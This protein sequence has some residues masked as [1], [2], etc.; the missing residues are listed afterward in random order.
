ME[1]F[2][3]R[4]D[5]N[6]IKDFI[7]PTDRLRRTGKTTTLVK[8]YILLA[9]ENKDVTFQIRDHFPAH[10]ADKHLVEEIRKQIAK[11]NEERFEKNGYRTRFVMTKDNNL[12]CSHKPELYGYKVEKSLP[13]PVNPPKPD[14]Y[15]PVA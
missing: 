12:V 15:Y 1:E 5:L 6:M 9:M 3:N 8:A 10:E 4:W 7:D 11:E 13:R 2:K 14:N